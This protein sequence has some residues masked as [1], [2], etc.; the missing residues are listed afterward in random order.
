[1][2]TRRLAK[3]ILAAAEEGP[4]PSDSSVNVAVLD[5]GGRLL[6]Y[7]R[8]DGARLGSV[9]LA[10]RKEVSELTLAFVGKV[11]KTQPVTTKY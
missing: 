9:D 3:E 8:M 5:G 10:I 4:Q 2:I 7:I 1:M 6:A 11:T